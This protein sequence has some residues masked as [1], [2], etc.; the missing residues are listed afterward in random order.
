VAYDYRQA[1]D[2]I[3]GV[4]RDDAGKVV[5]FE[6]GA[7]TIEER[8]L[9]LALVEFAPNIEPSTTLLARMLNTSQRQVR[10]LL[11]RVEDKGL[12]GVEHRPGHRSRYVL[13]TLDP[14][15]SVLPDPGP[16]VLPLKAPLRTD[17]P[18]TPDQGSGVPRTN[19][20]PKQTIE[21]DKKADKD[22]EPYRLVVP[23]PPRKRSKKAKGAEVDPISYRSVVDAYF[24]GFRWKHGK[25]PVFGSAEGSAVNRLLGKLNGNAVE[26]CRR[27]ANAF[28]S[29]RGAS[30][31]IGDIATKP[32][33]FATLEPPRN[34][35]PTGPRQ[36][37]HQTFDVSAHEG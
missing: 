28:G 17:S 3:F 31:T 30:V 21:A 29:W 16:I 10:R 37:N 24:V 13:L 18:P 12:L 20:P 22:P 25:D 36:P 5:A 15:L 34:G 33:A 2:G 1:R 35:R 11:R 6:A 32:D 19:S 26:A 9:L 14:G 4:K 8:A 7:A 27:I 23:E